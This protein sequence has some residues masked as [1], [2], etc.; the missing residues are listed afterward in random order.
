MGVFLS[1]I[2]STSGGRT[3]Y[4]TR[5]D[6]VGREPT[7]SGKVWESRKAGAGG[8]LAT[9][10]RSL[11]RRSGKRKLAAARP[12]GDDVCYLRALATG[13]PSGLTAE[14]VFSKRAER[15]R[16]EPGNL[17]FTVCKASGHE[18]VRISASMRVTETQAKPLRG[19]HRHDSPA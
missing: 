12:T 17:R 4:A 9:T 1:G 7:G 5:P 3:R 14:H 8:H 18:T 19:R 10:K 11:R 13:T 2:K 16:P 6:I 15:S